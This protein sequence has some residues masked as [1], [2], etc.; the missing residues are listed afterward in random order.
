ME[1]FITRHGDDINGVYANNDMM[2]LGT[3]QAIDSSDLEDIAITGIDGSEVWVEKFKTSITTDHRTTTRRDGATG[4][5]I[6]SQ[7]YR[8]GGS[9]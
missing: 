4:N 6:R 1:D 3:M 8:W 5:R 7:C 2:A 9:R